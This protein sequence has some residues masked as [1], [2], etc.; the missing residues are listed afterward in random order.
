[1]TGW[2][3]TERKLGGGK[4]KAEGD[5][6]VMVMASQSVLLV[7][8]SISRLTRLG[9]LERDEK[10]WLSSSELVNADKRKRFWKE[11]VK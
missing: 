5:G 11:W 3:G 4:A 8:C 10:A 9:T 6:M 7:R 1:M 2:V